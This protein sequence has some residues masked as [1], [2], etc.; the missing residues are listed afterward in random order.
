M[1][2]F[3]LS[4]IMGVE[5]IAKKEIEKQGGKIEEVTDRLITFSGPPELIPRVN[6]WSRVGNKMYILL[7][8]LDYV[9]DFDTLFD[10]VNK[11]HFKKYFKKNFPIVVK[12]TSQRSVLDSIPT[13]QKICK[14]SIVENLNGGTGQTVL[15]DAEL[16][17]MEIFVLIIDNKVRILLNTSGSALHMRG[18]RI[19]AG[20]API[21]ESLAAAIVLLS[22]WRFKEYLYD[23]FCG[24]GT[25]AIEALMIAKNIAP[26]LKRRFAFENLGLVQ[27]EM[28]ENERALARK[29]Q[30]DGDYKIYASDMD[31]KMI[32]IAMNNTERAGLQGGIHFSIKKFEELLNDNLSGTLVSNP[33]Y[34]GRLQE[35][36]LPG[37]YKTIDKLFRVN[38]KLKGGVITSYLD[39]DNLIK[40]ENYKKRKLYNGGELCYFYRRK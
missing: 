14:K 39:F 16:E 15:E 28:A 8:E 17:K 2:K 6:F 4:T 27:W 1:Q 10:M 36:N 9:E 30:F 40:L 7:D 29:K 12:A 25:I 11:I 37:I 22:N 26:G 5:S 19:E 20:E 34:G 24:S 32:E 21:K 18:Y 13:I 3:V 38:P 23:P 31:E 33:P 35:N